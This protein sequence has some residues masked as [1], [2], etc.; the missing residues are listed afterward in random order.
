MAI[1]VLGGLIYATALTLIIVPIIYD[2]FNKETYKRKGMFA[3]LVRGSTDKHFRMN[4]DGTSTIISDDDT[5]D[6]DEADS[7][8]PQSDEE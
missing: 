5:Y 2:L 7:A 1:T 3:G 4:A 8:L 6:I